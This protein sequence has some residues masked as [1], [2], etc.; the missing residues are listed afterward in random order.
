[1]KGQ[2]QHYFG[3][4]RGPQSK[5]TAETSLPCRGERGGKGGSPRQPGKAAICESSRQRR[6]PVH[7]A[8]PST[9]SRAA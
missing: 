5:G 6:G 7:C 8:L 9:R 2:A 1:M 3:G 4:S